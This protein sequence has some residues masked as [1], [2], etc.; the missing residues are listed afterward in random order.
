MKSKK[1]RK[2]KDKSKSKSIKDVPGDIHPQGGHNVQQDEAS[3][4]TM[5][6]QKLKSLPEDEFNLK[7]EKMLVGFLILDF[8]IEIEL[9][10]HI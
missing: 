6:Q 10:S 2:D 7:F 3:E 8:E 9:S 4:N 1:N 5:T